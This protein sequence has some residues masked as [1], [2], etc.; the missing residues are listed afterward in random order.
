MRIDIKVKE[1]CCGWTAC[2]S[3]CPYNA[4]TMVDD[5]SGFLYPK[6]DLSKCVDCGLCVK[7]CQFKKGY[8]RYENFETPIVYAGRQKQLEEIAKSQTGGL[9]ALIYENF[10]STGGCA[11][12]VVFDSDQNIMF[13]C[14]KNVDE[15]QQFR[16]S[17]YVQAEIQ[18]VFLQIKEY[19]KNSQKVLFIGS[20]CQVAGLKSYIPNRFHKELLTVDLVCHCNT[21]PRLWKSY[22]LYLEQKYHSK[23]VK[24][25]FRNKRFGWH[26]CLETY[27]LANGKEIVTKSYDYLFFKHLSIRPSCTICPFTNLHRVGDVTIGDYWGWEKNHVEWNDDFGI[28]LIL[29]NSSKG[30]ELLKL[31][32][33]KLDLI[34]TDT[35][36]CLQPQLIN[37]IQKN[38]LQENF[39]K[40]YHNKGIKYVLYKYG[41]LNY[42][43][44]F[45]RHLSCIKRKLLHL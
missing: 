3:I 4:I 36:D 32:T 10:L 16:G 15:T 12:G 29:I 24:A 2:A 7:T 35:R 38:P 13:S 37:P 14:A 6:V 23:I 18:N 33:P 9:A 39:F 27:N 44:R 34:Q 19:L 20:P 11:Y 42:L 28:N 5:L 8:E 31:I 45:K 25:D 17:K 21:S 22:I 1:N 40:D 26:K 41:D 43:F 30:T